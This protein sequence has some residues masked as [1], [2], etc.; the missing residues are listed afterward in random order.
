MNRRSRR[1]VAL[2]ALAAACAGGPARAAG[3]DPTAWPP[4]VVYAGTIEVHHWPEQQ[5]LARRVA[6]FV[7]T[8]RLPALPPDALHGERIRIVLAPDPARFAALTGGRVPDWGA[9]V[10]FPAQGLVVIP[11]DRAAAPGIPS[12]LQIVTHELAHVALHRYLEP[13]RIPRWFNEGYAV[14]AAGQFDL[15]A[16]WRLRAAFLTGRA[17]PL[18]S[19]ILGWPERAGDA[20][21]AYLLSASAVRYLHASGGDFAMQRFLERWREGRTMEEALLETYG[22]TLHQFERHWA[23]HVRGRYG[24][25]VLLAQAGVVWSILTLLA[26][27]LV[28]RRRRRDRDRLERLRATEIPDAPAFWIEP[29]PGEAAEEQSG[30]EPET[31]GGDDDPDAEEDPRPSDEGTGPR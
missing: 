9:G 27:L 11:T 18:D 26:V 17:P 7:P 22:L 23:R 2:L 8:V 4:A 20:R 6:D 16:A 3:Q 31:G 15:E 28:L 29:P 21:I 12:L 25:L 10:A 19:L 13:A 30:G 1:L 24:W 14:W 5:T